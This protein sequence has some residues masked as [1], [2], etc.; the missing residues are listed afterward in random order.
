MSGSTDVID[1]PT[2]EM[3]ARR[4]TAYRVVSRAYFHLPIFVVFL[5]L[6]GFEVYWIGTALALY[7]LIV[8]VG[9]RLLNPI[10][11]R[12]SL[13][14]CL[15]LGELTKFVGLAI[16]L[17][18]VSQGSILAAQTLSALGF[19]LTAG[20][21]AALASTLRSGER[22]RAQ[23]A[24]TQMGMFI[25]SFAA[26]F[27]GALSFGLWDR[28]PFVLSGLSS[29]G[30]AVLLHRAGVSL[31]NGVQ[32]TILSPAP[33]GGDADEDGE[34][35]ENRPGLVRFWALYYS[36]NRALLL[37]VYTF[38]LPLLLFLEANLPIMMFGAVLGLYT[39]F[40]LIA[41]RL[42]LRL[43]R[44]LS[45]LSFFYLGAGVMLVGLGLLVHGSVWLAAVSLALLGLA[46]G[47]IRPATM[48]F[49]GP[50]MD[51]RTQGSRQRVLQGL[52]QRQGLIQAGLLVGCG[53]WLHLTD[54]LQ[55]AILLYVVI[56]FT[57]QAIAGGLAARML[58]RSGVTQIR[59]GT[60][61]RG[62]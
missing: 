61:P 38:L 30:A 33:P 6:Q 55:F 35:A 27:V 22:Y 3:L 56:A 1:A 44:R 46:G 50:A 31:R 23:E 16:L 39:V 10:K 57:S 25:A 52:E 4:V 17:L 11:A 59:Q 2:R 21:D 40:G 5:V 15:V 37:S 7:G 12:L 24:S 45:P 43:T 47:I 9:S 28:L 41:A 49:L 48:M 13:S 20:T 60:A 32:T 51:G 36:I 26:G 58:S 14:G 62:D 18:P 8:A 29:L 19:C 54:S 53:L 34:Q 42:S